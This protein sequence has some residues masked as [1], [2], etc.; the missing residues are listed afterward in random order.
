MKNLAQD[1]GDPSGW[2]EPITQPFAKKCVCG[3]R[4]TIEFWLGVPFRQ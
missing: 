2:P 4:F 1:I 3:Y